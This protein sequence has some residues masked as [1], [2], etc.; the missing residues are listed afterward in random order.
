MFSIFA[1][2]RAC[3]L[4]AP[5]FSALALSQLH[6][7]ERSA[8][9]RL[10]DTPDWL[11]VSG[12]HRARFEFLDGAN[13]FGPSR[14]GLAFANGDVYLDNRFVDALG[15]VSL[16]TSIAVE[17]RTGRFRFGAELMDSRSYAP[18]ED[19]DCV[20]VAGCYNPV[21]IR[22]NALEPI[23][24]YIGVKLEDHRQDDASDIVVGRFT[25]HLG[26]GRLV[27]RSEFRNFMQS[28]LGARANLRISDNTRL[29]LFYTLPYRERSETSN[30]IYYDVPHAKSH[31][32]GA[33][34][35]KE[36]VLSG[37]I[38]EAY[39]F[40]EW[41][42]RP[43]YCYSAN[44]ALAGMRL[45][46]GARIS[47]APKKGAF[48]FDVEVALQFTDDAFLRDFYN[49]GLGYFAHAEI[50]RAFNHSSNLRIAAR[51]DLASG[52]GRELERQTC[53]F[54]GAGPTPIENPCINL[55]KSGTAAFNPLFGTFES[56][57]G[58]EGLFGVLSYT[59]LASAGLLVEGEPARNLDFM[60][61]YRAAK[62]LSTDEI[63][64]PSSSYLPAPG[65][66]LS[67][68]EYSSGWG[69]Q[70][71]GRLRYRLLQEH[72]ELTL[73]GAIFTQRTKR[74]DP[75]FDLPPYPFPSSI[76]LERETTFYG[77]TSIRAAF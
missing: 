41:G 53:Y 10:L 18:V 30:V 17:A 48:D 46:P 34:Y 36:N 51:F 77:Y 47:R 7:A 43:E 27:G 12:F 15:V 68:T 35:E 8:P 72:V 63:S 61:A 39:V 71:D 69:H 9:Q 59:D 49:H 16:Q 31:F 5:F 1:R 29:N 62:K 21:S 28:Y 23:Q 50:G 75:V 40:G 57:F 25:M 37:A 24:S 2:K 66:V 60:I 19:L 54:A 4:L 65:G 73:G 14:T 13:E 55:S 64:F 44:C 32:W 56:D 45:T 52:D 20:F 3:A 58:P 42:A 33:H 76:S 6:A 26:S 67:A 22:T 38:A 70:L 74:E 11:T